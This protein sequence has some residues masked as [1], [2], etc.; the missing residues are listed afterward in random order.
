M[1][2]LDPGNMWLCAIEVLRLEDRSR[3]SLQ[4]ESGI[5]NSCSREGQQITYSRFQQIQVIFTSQT[6]ESCHPSTCKARILNLPRSCTKQR[7]LL[8][9]TSPMNNS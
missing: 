7:E 9:A 3:L 2:H 8:Q 4:C 1:C 5:K 6:Y